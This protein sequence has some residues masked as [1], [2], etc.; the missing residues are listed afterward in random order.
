MEMVGKAEGN[1]AYVS[2]LLETFNNIIQYQYEGAKATFLL[3]VFSF[4]LHKYSCLF[5]C[6]LF[7]YR[8]RELDLCAG[9]AQRRV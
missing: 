6:L 2:L 3:N 1:H 7:D 5:V 4:C 8:Q 9:E